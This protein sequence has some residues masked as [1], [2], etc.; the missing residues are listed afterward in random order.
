MP[1]LES[2]R[3]IAHLFFS[4]KIINRVIK[5]SQI[6]QLFRL[7]IPPKKLGHCS[8]LYVEHHRTLMGKHNPINRMCM[9]VNSVSN[10]FDFFDC[11]FQPIRTSV[12]NHFRN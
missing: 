7:Y 11:P 2:H 3:F 5:C 12:I 6:L 8:L 10:L 9:N 1:T 4:Y